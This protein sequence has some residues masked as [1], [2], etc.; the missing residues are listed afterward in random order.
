MEQP[1]PV[2]EQSKYG[3][4]EDS[5]S[6]PEETPP[7][8]LQSKTLASMSA[9]VPFASQT[10][11]SPFE[12]DSSPIMPSAAITATSTTAADNRADKQQERF[13]DATRNTS[14]LH[15]TLAKNIASVLGQCEAVAELDELRVQVGKTRTADG[16][17]HVSTAMAEKYNSTESHLQQQVQA[18]HDTLRATAIRTKAED[19]RYRVARQLLLRYWKVI[20]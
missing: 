8:L 2:M 13:N 1:D 20:V 14:V 3:H 5:T 10:K 18:V 4:P 16:R 19:K 12:D 11:E 17:A 7:C 15:T 6:I 9:Q